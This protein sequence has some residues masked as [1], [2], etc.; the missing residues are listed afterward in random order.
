[1]WFILTHLCSWESDSSQATAQTHLNLCRKT[2][3]L[4]AKLHDWRAGRKPLR[5]PEVNIMR[6]SEGQGGS[7]SA[8]KAM[9]YAEQAG[10]VCKV[11]GPVVLVATRAINLQGRDI[12]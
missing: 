2:T 3:R 8:G 9:Q 5:A 1:M 10:D 11:T 7:T 12:H 4:H 6:L